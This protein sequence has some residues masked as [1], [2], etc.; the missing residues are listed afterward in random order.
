MQNGKHGAFVIASTGEPSIGGGWNNQQLMKDCGLVPYLLHKNHGFRSVMVGLKVDKSYPYLKK[1]LRGLELDFLSEDS[2]KARTDY[3]NAHA[4]EMDLLIL[5]GAY[6]AYMPLVEHYKNVRS[7]G[8]IYLATDMNIAW[9][10][11]LPH[12]NPQ[13][14][15]FLHAC[16][17]VAAS[18]R[19]TQ[20]YLSAKWSVPVDLIRNGWYN[21]YNVNFNHVFNRKE[22]IILTVGR[23]GTNQKQNHI[24]LEAFAKVAAELP[25]WKLKLVGNVEEKF[26]PYIEKFFAARPEL[27]DRVIFTGLIEDKVALINEYKRAKIFCLASNFEGG[28]PNVAAEALF[29]GDFVICSSVDAAGDMT[30]NGN[31]GKIFP[32]G[33]A[34]A[35]AK[36]FSEVCRDNDL[37]GNGSRH[38]FDYARE[39]FD[40]NKIV[41]R[42]N[43][44]LYGGDGI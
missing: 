13:Y 27:K 37:I 12:E 24:M 1:Y 33:D 14:K 28:T 29:S 8:K 39:Q 26:K 15:K 7:D 6:P 20:K 41:A 17:V 22:N 34:D 38:A 43:Y 25:D 9:A 44:L 16:D 31:C 11:R 23:I 42:L 35:L 5:Y 3:V 32:I 10:D 18:C 30:D 36:L 19:A 4:A 21:F 40:M 2:L